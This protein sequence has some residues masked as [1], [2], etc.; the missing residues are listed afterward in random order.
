MEF[1]VS[2]AVFDRGVAWR[3]DSLDVD[4][5]LGMVARY[6]QRLFNRD[7]LAEIGTRVT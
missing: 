2:G 5:M 3:Q 4:Q 6:A 1:A 7:E